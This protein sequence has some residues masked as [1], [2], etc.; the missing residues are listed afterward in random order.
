MVKEGILYCSGNCCTDRLIAETQTPCLS[1]FITDR[2][3]LFFHLVGRNAEGWLQRA[4][5]KWPQNLDY[6]FMSEVARDMLVVNDCAEQNIKAITDYNSCTRDVNGM[7]D[8]I[9]LV[10]EDR[11]SL[12]PNLNRENLLHA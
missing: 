12:T 4:P 8:N 3:W 2:S 5:E 7:L 11:C 9:V 6:T 10:G 1:T